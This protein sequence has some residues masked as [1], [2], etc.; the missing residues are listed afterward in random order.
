VP[1]MT[2]LP[3]D[4]VVRSSPIDRNNFNPF[5]TSLPRVVPYRFRRAT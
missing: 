1:D 4:A 5:V 3:A 2:E